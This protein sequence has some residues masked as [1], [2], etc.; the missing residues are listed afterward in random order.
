M[1]LKELIEELKTYEQEVEVDFTVLVKEKIRE[2]WITITNGDN[3][4]KTY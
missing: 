2:R 4:E 3:H 1:K